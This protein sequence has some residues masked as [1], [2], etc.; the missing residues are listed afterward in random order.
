MKAIKNGF[1]E[2]EKLF[3]EYAENQGIEVGDIDRSGSCAIVALII[4]D[5]CYIGNTGDSRACMSVDGGT[6]VYGLSVDH[7][8]TDDVEVNRILSNNGRI[9]QNASIVN[10]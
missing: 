5:M 2:A 3:L 6:K 8:P 4:D 10:V 7:K 9:Y 1:S